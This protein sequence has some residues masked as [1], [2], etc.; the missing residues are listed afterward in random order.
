MVDQRTGDRIC[1]QRDRSQLFGMHGLINRHERRFSMGKYKDTP[2]YKVISMRV[3]SVERKELE[4][5]ASQYSLSISDM[6][7]Q[8]MEAYTRSREPVAAGYR[9]I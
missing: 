8:A 1:S 4:Q 5:I 7:R 3:N 2:R 6:M 9:N